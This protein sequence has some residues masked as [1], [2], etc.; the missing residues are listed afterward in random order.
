VRTDEFYFVEDTFMGRTA[1]LDAF[2]QSDLDMQG[3]HIINCPDLTGGGGGMPNN[4]PPVAHEWI[5]QYNSGNGN[6]GASRP[7]T[8]DLG[9]WPNPVGNVGRVLTVLGATG[10]DPD[11]SATY[12]WV[13]PAISVGIVNVRLTGLSSGN[14]VGDG[15]HDDTLAIQG[16][17]NT[18]AS[19]GYTLYFPAGHYRVTAKLTVPAGAKFTMLGDSPWTSLIIMDLLVTPAGAILDLSGSSGVLVSRMGFDGILNTAATGQV[20]PQRHGILAIGANAVIID[21]CVIAY[22]S[23]YGI[24]IEQS[25][26]AR[27]QDTFVGVMGVGGII[28]VFCPQS[29]VR[30]NVVSDAMEG[31]IWVLNSPS[32]TIASNQ[33]YSCAANTAGLYAIDSDNSAITGNVVQQC[34]VG[35]LIGVSSTRAQGSSWDQNVSYGYAFV[36]NTISRNYFGGVNVFNAHGFK[37]TGNVITDNG[38]GASDG[39]TGYTI[40]PGMMV[41]GTPSNGAGYQLGDVVTLDPANGVSTRVAKAVVT[42]IGNGGTILPEGLTVIDYG[43]YTTFPTNPVLLT[44]GHATTAAKCYFTDSRIANGGSGYMVGQVLFHAAPIY[45]TAHGAYNPVR[46]MVNA[47]G[48]GGAVTSYVVLDGG[49]Y[50]DTSFGTL[51]MSQ[52]AF[53]PMDGPI[54]VVPGLLS[55]PSVSTGAGPLAGMDRAD[56]PPTGSGFVIAPCWGRRYSVLNSPAGAGATYNLETYHWINSGVVSGNIISRCR[57]GNGYLNLGTV[58]PSP[59]WTTVPGSD[60]AGYIVFTGNSMVG[61]A[62][63]FSGGFAVPGGHVTRDSYYN[64]AA[65]PTGTGKSSIFDAEV[66]DFSSPTRVLIGNA[67]LNMIE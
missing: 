10:T 67:A 61:N 17:I 53:A 54:D 9:D 25:F 34:A 57:T 39:T 58:N 42:G 20:V 27:V 51:P 38:A 19:A 23:G 16:A 21:T 35:A 36:G 6:F 2:A 29:L 60:R 48:A 30:G 55:D 1:L 56:L 13:T 64:V 24:I 49:G 43:A 62:T 32:C 12:G 46:V 28:L 26:E 5:N 59:G 37:I 31:G 18:V 4:F 65:T 47:V 44:G 7:L 11:V 22:C 40:E 66:Y 52:D 33:I 8:T 41:L 3:H 45:P 14:A 63:P 50:T 15:V